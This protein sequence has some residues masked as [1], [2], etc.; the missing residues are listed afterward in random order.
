MTVALLVP[1]ALVVVLG[2]ACG[3]DG[4]EPPR[5]SPPPPVSV[6]LSWKRLADAPSQRTEVTAAAGR[7]G[8]IVVVGGYRADGGTLST[9]EIYDP[10]T[11]RWERG[12]DLPLPVNHA[13]AAAVDGTVHVFGGYLDGNVA[14]GAAFRLESAGWHAIADL[15]EARAAGTAVAIAGKV[16]VAG[17]IGPGAGLATRML[18]YTTATD[19]WSTV[20][21]PPTRREHLGGAGYGT[22]VYTVGGRTGAGNLAA[23][24]SYDTATGAWRKLPDLPTPRGGLSAAMS[25]AG[26]LVAVGGE[27]AATFAEAEGY[28]VRERTW[29]ALPALPTPRHGIGVVTVGTVLYVMAGGPK[30]GLFVAS[31]NEAI[32]LAPL[33]PC[34]G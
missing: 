18:V 2:G 30:P 6:A 13:M 33:A 26:L 19:S 24:E 23:L 29:R 25:C 28:D 8:R 3:T 14:S 11:D 5:P 12:P 9:V 1:S 4:P 34:A 15:P 27:A 22:V 20:D 32:D 21:G 31:T 17:G 16:Y 10:A 7:D